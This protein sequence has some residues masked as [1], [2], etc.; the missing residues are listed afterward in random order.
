MQFPLRGVAAQARGADMTTRQS[1]PNR[2]AS[3]TH[4]IRV[5][6][7]RTVY[8]STHAASPPLE[9]FVRVRG[10][11]CTA[12]TVA[13]YDCLARLVSLSLQ[14]GAPLEP[15]GKML[16]GV[17]AEPG[18]IVVDHPSIH[19]CRSLPDAIGQHLLSLSQHP[20]HQE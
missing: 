3:V 14:Y 2:R 11:D 17:H 12:E 20:S 1:L 10:Q 6:G 15:V 19:F 4:K 13:L 8:L 7:T 18:G 5:G 9:L 16:Q